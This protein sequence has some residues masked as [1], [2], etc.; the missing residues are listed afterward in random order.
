MK[1]ENKRLKG[2]DSLFGRIDVLPKAVIY[3]DMLA[4]LST[5]NHQNSSEKQAESI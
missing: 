3:S 2:Y 5:K 1:R 4:R